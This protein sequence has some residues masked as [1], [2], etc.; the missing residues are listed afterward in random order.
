[1]ND[2]EVVQLI[3][4]AR[5]GELTNRQLLTLVFPY[6][7]HREYKIPLT[8]IMESMDALKFLE[9]V[10]WNNII[11]RKNYAEIK[12]D[13]SKISLTSYIELWWLSKSVFIGAD[14]GREQEELNY[15]IEFGTA[16]YTKADGSDPIE[17]PIDIT[18]QGM[19]VCSHDLYST[20]GRFDAILK[21]IDGPQ[22]V[23][24]KMV[25]D[26]QNKISHRE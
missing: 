3:Q 12:T 16:T 2:S 7:V 24:K 9:I 26:I 8:T 6:E 23:I 5:A 18:I 17:I 21:K 10:I 1:M 11:L 15:R 20:K 14:T 19:L 25:V 4:A 13:V 22:T